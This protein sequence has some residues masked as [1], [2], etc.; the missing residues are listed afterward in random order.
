MRKTAQ[1]HTEYSRNDFILKIAHFAKA[2]AK[3]NGQKWFILGRNF[4]EQKAYKNDSAITL[5]YFYA[6]IG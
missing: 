4:K 2:I 6:K 5:L 3:Q 1:K